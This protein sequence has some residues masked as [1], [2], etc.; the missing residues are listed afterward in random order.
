VI[1]RQKNLVI[2]GD[3]SGVLMFWSVEGDGEQLDSLQGHA[4]QVNKIIFHG[5][6]FFTTSKW[7]PSRL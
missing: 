3:L 1:Q 7:V 2:S 5:G 4:K 6:R